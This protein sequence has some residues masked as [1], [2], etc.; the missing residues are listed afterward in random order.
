[1]QVQLGKAARSG[2]LEVSSCSTGRP[3]TTDE[4]RAYFAEKIA[5]RQA[6]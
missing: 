4:R 6:H 5:K 3:A 2:G 1:V